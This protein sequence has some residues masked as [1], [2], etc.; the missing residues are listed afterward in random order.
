M[1]LYATATLQKKILYFLHKCLFVY[2]FIW[3]LQL[4]VTHKLSNLINTI[5][6]KQT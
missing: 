6:S 1:L 4:N 5:Y 3:Q 2:S